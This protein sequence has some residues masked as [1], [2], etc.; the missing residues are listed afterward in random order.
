VF[1]NHDTPVSEAS[2][3]HDAVQAHSAMGQKLLIYASRLRAI[4]ARSGGVKILK[5]DCYSSGFGASG[6]NKAYPNPGA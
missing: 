5:R 3:D 1:E 6:A 2:V 4:I